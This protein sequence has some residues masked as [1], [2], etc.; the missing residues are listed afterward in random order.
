MAVPIPMAILRAPLPHELLQDA[1]VGACASAAARGVLSRTR[2]ASSSAPPAHD[3]LLVAPTTDS[4]SIAVLAIDAQQAFISED[5][6]ALALARLARLVSVQSRIL[7]CI[8]RLEPA[9]PQPHFASFQ[10]AAAA[11]EAQLSSARSVRIVLIIIPS[12]ADAG[13][14]ATE[15]ETAGTPSVTSAVAAAAAA[16]LDTVVRFASSLSRSRA[17]GIS[18]HIAHALKGDG[19]PEA[20]G[21]ALADAIS[22]KPIHGVALVAGFGGLAAVARMPTAELARSNKS[23]LDARG[24]AAL[25]ALLDE[26]HK[27]VS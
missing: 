16:V 1:L 22:C 6:A 18:L 24:V 7:V 3:L 2:V 9:S 5:A 13:A 14:D 12:H 8:T 15:E 20:I 19:S 17:D 23:P 26:R 27:I 11:Q 4:F 25:T 21:G 10:R